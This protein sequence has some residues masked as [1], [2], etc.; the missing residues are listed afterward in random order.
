VRIEGKIVEVSQNEAKSLGIN[1]TYGQQNGTQS[2]NLSFAA[3]QGGAAIAG[4]VDTQALTQINA[5][6][7]ALVTR[8]L[9]NVISSPSLTVKDGQAANINGTDEIVVQRATVITTAAGTTTSFEFTTQEVPIT[10]GVTP[11]ISK[12]EGR[13]EMLIN[14]TLSSVV[15][16][17]VGGSPAPVT[18]QTIQTTVMVSN[19]E[20]AVIGGLTKDSWVKGMSGVPI[21]SDIPLLGL[22]FK[23][24]RVRKIKKDVIIFITPTIVED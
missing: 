7:D 13:V 11:K 6:V 17:S 15:G 23:G 4:F 18:S 10:L 22:L 12:E 2:T 20:T 5:T 21:L 8:D 3:P 9:A 14:F 24:E 1:W 19:G 16:E